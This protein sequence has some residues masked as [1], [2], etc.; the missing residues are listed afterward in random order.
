MIDDN[1]CKAK[2]SG[3]VEVISDF[4]KTHPALPRFYLGNTRLIKSYHNQQQKEDLK[5][6]SPRVGS[7]WNVS[8]S[9]NSIIC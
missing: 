8:I 3:L 7:I 5:R 1:I 4:N 6:Q 2:L 9:T